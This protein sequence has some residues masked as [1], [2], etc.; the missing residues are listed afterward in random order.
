MA[1][2]QAT[3]SVVDTLSSHTRV[4]VW[5]NR[6]HMSVDI[7]LGHLKNQ[8][9]WLNPGDRIPREVLFGALQ[10]ELDEGRGWEL[11]QLTWH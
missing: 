3:E 6:L 9:I 11:E 2:D 7:L 8:G 4:D 10:A 1:T 5:A